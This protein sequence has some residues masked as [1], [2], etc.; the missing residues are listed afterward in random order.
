MSSTEFGQSK[1][2]ETDKT[3]AVSINENLIIQSDNVQQPKP[4]LQV[5]EPVYSFKDSAVPLFHD[6]EAKDF[7]SRWDKIQT[8]FVDE[9]RKAVEEANELVATTMNRLT[10]IFAEERTKLE[11]EWD[12][13]ENVS[14]EDLR[15]VL[16]RYR[17][18]FNRLLT[19]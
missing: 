3:N 18:F 8:G 5:S 13:G 19:V 15:V 1:Q 9:P 16:M 17:S 4:S 14:T 10:A 7:Q 6:T 2:K 12:K 11:G